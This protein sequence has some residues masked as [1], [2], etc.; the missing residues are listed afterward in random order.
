[1]L[2]KTGPYFLPSLPSCV[3]DASLS[4]GNKE[5]GG[6]LELSEVLRDFLLSF[7]S[8]SQSIPINY[9]NNSM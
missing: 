2:S 1:M 3:W 9:C 8:H 7:I 5:G 6:D 4:K